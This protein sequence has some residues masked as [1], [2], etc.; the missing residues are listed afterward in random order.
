M[1]LEYMSIYCTLFNQGKDIFASRAMPV[2][3]G[4]C[5]GI[6][7]RALFT[8]EGDAGREGATRC[9]SFGDG[10]QEDPSPKGS[11]MSD[12]T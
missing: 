11:K 1:S 2:S 7:S 5:S 4:S 8:E 9:F 12:L 3:D 10:E 6:P